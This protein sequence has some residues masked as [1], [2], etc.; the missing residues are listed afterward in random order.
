MSANYL[1][2][3]GRLIDPANE[4]DGI[5]DL[6]ISD[7]KIK[8]IGKDLESRS[9][10]TIDAGS[11]IV[12]P[13]LIDMHTHLREPGREDE[14]TVMSG[15]RAA[16][17]GGFTSLACMPN[18]EPAIDDADTVASVKETIK[19]DALCNVFIVAA[20]TER[21]NGKRLTDFEG[22]KASGIS[23]LSDDG[24]S[25]EDEDIMLAALKGARACGLIII[26]HCEDIKI[27]SG[28]VVNGGFIATK[29]GLRGIPG[30]SEYER[31]RRDIGLARRTSSKIHIAH[32]SLKESVD[33]IMDARR[34]GAAVTAETCPHYFSLT[35]ER[36]AT[37]D[38]NTKMNPPLRTKEDVEAIKEAIKN[39]AIDVIATDHAPHTDAEK[40]VE[41]EFAPFGIIG[42]ETALS[43]AVAELVDKKTISWGGLITLMSVNPSRI[44]NIDRGSLKAGAAADVVIIDPNKEYIYTKEMIESKSKNSPFINWRLKGKATHVF[45]SGRLVM[46]DGVILT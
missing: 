38:T 17:R 41:F 13:G 27:S 30:R 23:A 39:G 3:N 29:M 43:L 11:R 22:M 28:G 7:G 20:I 46:K 31:V 36:C 1:I 8:E 6:F 44:L 10:E 19:K 4:V 25:V 2:K 5:L 24:S 12:A 18:T 9:S 37:Y 26:D 34:N 15:T 35:D 45:V 21:R 40:D 32:V 33:I 42:L 14:E 16:I